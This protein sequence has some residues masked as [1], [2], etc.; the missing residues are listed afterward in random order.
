MAFN[1][2]MAPS[3][4]RH[5]IKGKRYSPS[6]YNLAAQIF[7]MKWFVRCSFLHYM[8]AVRTYSHCV[9]MNSF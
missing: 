4:G 1:T 5:E 3:R 8:T 2:A 6:K 7:F 9:N